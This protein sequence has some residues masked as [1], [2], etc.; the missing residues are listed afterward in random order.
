MQ[1]LLEG[2][3]TVRRFPRFQPDL[4]WKILLKLLL[5]SL[6]PACKGYPRNACTMELKPHCGS[7]GNTYDNECLFC[8]EVAHYGNCKKTEK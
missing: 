2:V 7:D 4:K 8:N 1:G 5:L 6:Q 3:V